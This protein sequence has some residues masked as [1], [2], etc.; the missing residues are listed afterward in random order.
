MKNKKILIIV[1]SIAVFLIV[2]AAITYAFLPH[3]LN[4]PIKSIES[5]GSTVKLVVSTDDKVIIQNTEDRE[6]KIITFTDMHLDGKNETS[7]ETISH[8]VENITKEK[9]DLVVLGGDNVTSA[10]NKKRANQLCEIF[11]RL[12]VYWAPN[13]GNHEGDN[14]WS[15]TRSEMVEIFSS[16]PH[17]LMLEGKEDIWGDGNYCVEILNAD[18]TLMTTLFFMDTGDECDAETMAEYN[19][20]EGDTYNDGVKANQIEWY[21]EKV[22]EGKQNYG[23]YP[24]ILFVHIPLPQYKTEA[25]KGNFLYGEKLENVCATEFES[26]LFDCL[27]EMG[28]TTAVFCGHDH[29]NTFGVELDGI[30]LSYMQPSGYGSYT[31]ESRL[32]YEEKD[33]LQGYM[34]LT[35]QQNG[36]F[37]NEYHRNSENM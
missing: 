20:P 30:L 18:D 36:E 28:S 37:A 27:K 32:G 7:Y 34:L 10:F 12:G 14:S 25:E 3:S 26:G 29:L 23:E 21:R 11:E 19:L 2:A 31:A 6:F 15:I 33:W 24:S 22:N 16:Y 13:L 17:C 35:I 9:P 8:L 4:Y 5:I 1:C